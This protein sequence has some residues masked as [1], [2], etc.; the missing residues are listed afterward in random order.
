MLTRLRPPT[1]RGTDDWHTWPRALHALQHDSR[2]LA[3]LRTLACALATAA[4]ARRLP[5]KWG[6]VFGQ[7]WL[8]KSTSATMPEPLRAAVKLQPL[9]ADTALQL[10]RLEAKVDHILNSMA[11]GAHEVPAQTGIAT[12]GPLGQ[13]PGYHWCSVIDATKTV[14][15]YNTG[16][17]PVTVL[18]GFLG[19]GKTTL[20]KHLLQVLDQP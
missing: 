13:R 2:A 8:G 15:S 18:S 5:S 3:T 4:D 14:G 9:Q 10:S 12:D 7:E 16:P 20:L 11:P 6:G 17:L 19:A 1:P